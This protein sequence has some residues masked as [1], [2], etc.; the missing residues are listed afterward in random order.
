[1]SFHPDGSSLTELKILSAWGDPVK[2]TKATKARVK[3]L[4]DTDMVSVL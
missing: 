4:E 1:M 2:S 3:Y